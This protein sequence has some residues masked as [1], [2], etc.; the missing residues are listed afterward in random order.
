[1][2]YNKTYVYDNI[3]VTII[4]YTATPS[5]YCVLTPQPL[6]CYTECDEKGGVIC[7]SNMK[8][9]KAEG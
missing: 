9:A 1:M 4:Y 5:F 3:I 7:K 6:S 8:S 2:G